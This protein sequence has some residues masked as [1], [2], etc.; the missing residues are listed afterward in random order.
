MR[1]AKK[2]FR[3]ERDRRTVNQALNDPNVS[4]TRVKA[5]IAQNKK[6]VKYFFVIFFDYLI[7]LGVFVTVKYK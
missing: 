6:N 4:S 2:R 7:N 1:A 3:R 5:K